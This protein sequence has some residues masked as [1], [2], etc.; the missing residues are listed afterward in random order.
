MPKHSAI[1]IFGMTLIFYQA[2]GQTFKEQFNDLV[3]KKDTF[4]Q[5]QILEKWEKTDNNDP[6][7]FVAYFNYYVTKSQSEVLRI[8]QNPAGEDVLQ[9]MDQDTAIKDPVGFIFGGTYHDPELLNKAFDW[10]NQ[11]IEKHPNRLDMPFG[12]IHMYGEIEDYENFTEQIIHTINY[13]AVNKNQW[14]WADSKPL[15]KPKEIMLG[16]LQDYQ[17]K[18]YNTESDDLLDNM[19][20]IAETVLN[21]YPEHVESLSNLAIVYILRKQFDQALEPLFKAKKINPKDYVVLGNIAQSYK[22]KGEPKKAIKY[23]KLVIKYA[24]ENEK[25]YAQEQINELKQK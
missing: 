15:D 1:L 7:L 11:G 16:S 22:Q 6:E 21:L 2:T 20:R 9:I 25:K 12:K 14:T 3:H 13:S 19:K 5:K 24:D 10:I 4:G 18:L 23:F 17:I 8:G